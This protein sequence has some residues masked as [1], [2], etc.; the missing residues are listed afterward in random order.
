MKDSTTWGNILEE[1]DIIY[2]LFHKKVRFPIKNQAKKVR[3]PIKLALKKVRFPIFLYSIG[4][5]ERKMSQI[6]TI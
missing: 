3:F 6:S 4:V 2:I 5:F 1:H